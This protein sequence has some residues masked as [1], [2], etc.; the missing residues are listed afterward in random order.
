M[1]QGTSSSGASAT[2]PSGT[3]SPTSQRAQ[4]TSSSGASAT[5]QSG[6]GSSTSQRARGSSSR[7]ASASCPAPPEPG[8]DAPPRE[9]RSSAEGAEHRCLL[10]LGSGEVCAKCFESHAALLTH[11]H[12]TKGGQHGE[13]SSARRCVYSTQ[14]PVCLRIY[15]DMHYCRKHVQASVLRGRCTGRGSAF[16]QVPLFKTDMCKVC[17]RSFA[18]EA[19]L[20]VHVLQWHFPAQ[21]VRES[22]KDIPA[23]LLDGVG[24]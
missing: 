12:A 10:L 13:T 15:A 7:E 3:G 24:A 22:G 2:R 16:Q 6:T 4:G 11:Q 19:E 9:N 17:Q 8:S 23:L 14:C 20:R 1:A 21:L 5:K 18:C